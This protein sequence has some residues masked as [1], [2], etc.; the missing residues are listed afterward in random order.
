MH[1]YTTPILFVFPVP[2]DYHYCPPPPFS[3]MNNK[4]DNNG[5]FQGYG[6]QFEFYCFKPLLW[7]AQGV[8]ILIYPPPLRSYNSCLKQYSSN[9]CH[10]AGK[11]HYH[12]T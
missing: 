8:Y 12:Q 6:G 1:L 5:P 11:V 4:C 10:I 9:G 3:K 2:Y 7:D